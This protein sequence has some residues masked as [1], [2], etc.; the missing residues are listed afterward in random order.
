MSTT[1]HDVLTRQVIAGGT[2]PRAARIAVFVARLLLAG[3]FVNAASAKL[4]L[5]PQ[6]VTG[7]TQ[8][9][10][11][12]MLIFVGLLEVAGAVGLVVP[13]LSGFASI[14]TTALLAIITVVITTTAGPTWAA[15]PAACLAL[16]VVIAYL[17]RHQ[18]VRLA[19][20]LRRT[21]TAQT[22]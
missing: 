21:V 14:G 18:T 13:I 5:N 16:S 15:M 4:T 9:G 3:V 17:Q 6:A 2:R 8:L 11:V 19:R 12:P 7:F 10:G 1:T 20:W 22:R